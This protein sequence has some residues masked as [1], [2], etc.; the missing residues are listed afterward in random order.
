MMKRIIQLCSMLA[1]T[2][3]FTVAAHAQTNRIEANIPFDF[4]IGEKSY[5]AGDYVM[6]LSRVTLTTVALS[7]EDKFGNQLQ[8]ALLSSNGE[9]ASGQGRLMF[10]DHNSE[11]YL[12]KVV[13]GEHGFSLQDVGAK[14]D[15]SARETV[16]LAY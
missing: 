5:V 1:L 8:Q 13:T 7:L 6:K 4:N 11:R 14:K 12:S 16:A 10:E 2:V 9:A 3:V 15:G